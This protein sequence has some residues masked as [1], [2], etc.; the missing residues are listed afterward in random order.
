[1]SLGKTIRLNRLFSHPSRRLCSVAV[2]HWFGYRASGGA[3]GLIDLPATL[4]KLVPGK[5]SAVTMSK[6]TAMGCWGPYA[7]QVPLIVQA[8]C[9]TPDDRVI[10]QT[11]TPEECIRLGADAI[12][13]AIGVR[14]PNEG[15]FIRQ[16]CDGVT[17]AAHYD[18]PVV[19]H[20]YP[21]DFTGN[22]AKINFR[23]EEIE[24]AVRVGIE[25]G[26]DV[27]KVGYTGD[28]ASFK[29]I[30]SACPVPVVAAGGPKAPTFNA[31]LTAMGEAIQAGARGVTI[32][33]NV[34]G[35]PDPAA[36]LAAF[37][38][39]VLDGRA[40]DQAMARKA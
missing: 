3:A 5:P 8:G 31:A 40:T 19:A 25:C 24:W 4:A 9:F 38:A 6:G 21:R 23:P 7:G 17:A 36:A 13:I 20:I 27:I 39:V 18:L 28:V 1:M 33:R 15:K 22:E 37:K 14:G 12:A 11:T 32:G 30:I 26:A 10:E 35:E 29:Q 16:L 34:W 2:D